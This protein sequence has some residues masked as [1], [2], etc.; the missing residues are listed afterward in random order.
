MTMDAAMGPEDEGRLLWRSKW[1]WT[2]PAAERVALAR[3]REAGFMAKL[4][5]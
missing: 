2:G 5:R 4:T 3:Q 1:R